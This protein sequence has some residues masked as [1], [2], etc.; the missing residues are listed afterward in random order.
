MTSRAVV[1]CAAVAVVAVAACARTRT[2]VGTVDDGGVGEA[3]AGTGGASGGFATGGAGGGVGGQGGG[4]AGGSVPAAP[5]RPPEWNCG[6]T[7]FRDPSIAATPSPAGSFGGPADNNP[8]NK[9]AFAYP[10]AGSMHPINL[11]DITFHWRRGMGAS[12]TLFRIRATATTA[13]SPTYDFYVRCKTPPGT[14]TPP[15]QEECVYD[16]PPGAWLALASQNKGGEVSF[17]VAGT[18]DQGGPVAT[19]DARTLWF[20]PD[21]VKGGLYYWSVGLRGTYRLL[22]GASKATPFIRPESPSNPTKCAGCH[23]VSRDGNVI[24][25]SAGDDADK[26]HLM[27]VPTANPEMP[28]FVPATT[29]DSAIIAL[30]PDGSRALVS[31][32]SRLELR[33][34]RDGSVMGTVAPGFLGAEM[35]GYHPEWSPDGKEIVLTLS[36]M[37]DAEWAVKT[38]QIA[39]IPFNNGA[40]GPAQI[41]A[42]SGA[43]FHYYPSW[44]PD[45]KWIAFAS[46]PAG[47]GKLS[48]NQADSRL[49]LV[50]RSGGTIYDLV[51]ATQGVGRTSTWPKFAPYMQAGGNI[52]FITFNS[53]IDYGFIL[54]DNITHPDGGEPQLWMAALDLRKLSAGDKDPSLAPLWLPFQNVKQRNHLGYW[55]QEVGCRMNSDCGESENCEAGYCIRVV[56]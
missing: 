2:I 17:T 27:V 44:S 7:C 53:K 1:V 34:T 35:Q 25:F 8:V 23:V 21:G 50:S 39:V 41:V 47:A 9:P 3:G 48:Y 55:T 30:N 10:L 28:R 16:L 42:P 29:H 56:Q 13:G 45:G 54:K 24:A 6:P 14:D 37:R 49:R 12:Q 32:A 11:P 36:N 5:L 51:N 43:D 52:M 18:G 26:A 22:F 15:A 4:G 40:F 46:A 20:S 31:Y 33:D 38:G 19:S